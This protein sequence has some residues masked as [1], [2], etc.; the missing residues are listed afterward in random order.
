MPNALYHIRGL[1]RAI[2]WPA[3]IDLL[4]RR[5]LGLHR[6]ISIK[7]RGLSGTVEVAP[8]ESD[9]FVLSQIFG[10]REYATDSA[11]AQ[12]LHRVCADWKASD[13]SPL[14]IDGGANVGYS[15]LFFAEMFPEVTVVALE[16]DPQAFGRLCRNCQAHPQIKPLRAAL[17]RDANGVRL[18]TGEHGSWSH[19][20]GRDGREVPSTTLSAVMASVS[21]SRLLILKLDIEGSEKEVIEADPGVV[22]S[23]MC[24][25]IEP[26]DFMRPGLACLTPLFAAVADKQVD[27]V[28]SGENLFLFSPEIRGNAFGR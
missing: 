24:I 16:P 28:I 4:V 25:M 23:A 22:C 3:A 11:T 10:W 27:T 12:Q 26:H 1:T 13:I 8:T 18:Q 17:W 9:P 14:I 6:P 21:T 19:H 2:G 20:L 5:Y 15:A 7:V